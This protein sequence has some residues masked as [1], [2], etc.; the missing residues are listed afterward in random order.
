MKAA[1]DPSISKLH[2]LIG[3]CRKQKKVIPGD[4]DHNLFRPVLFDATP[5]SCT[6][7]AKT[8]FSRWTL[9]EI[10]GKV[11]EKGKPLVTNHVHL[12]LFG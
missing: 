1:P 7:L 9:M 6:S 5:A 4:L 2:P 8:Q 10:Q 3:I 12:V 11:L